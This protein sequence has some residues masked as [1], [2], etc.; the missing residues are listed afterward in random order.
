[1]N[2]KVELEDSFYIF[3]DSFENADVNSMCK[4]DM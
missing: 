3:Y 1:M 2:V 4:R